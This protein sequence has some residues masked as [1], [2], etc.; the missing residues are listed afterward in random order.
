MARVPRGTLQ[1]H[2]PKSV[3]GIARVLPISSLRFVLAIWVVLYHYGGLPIF[4]GVPKE[5]LLWGLRAVFHNSISGPAAVIIFFII[6]GFCIHFPNRKS[7]EV[8]SWRRYYARRYLR[9][10]IPMTVAITL[11]VP[12]KM[13]F[14]LFTES[15]LW[16]LLCEEVYYLLYPM[17]LVARAR[18]GWGTLMTISWSLAFLTVL[19]NPHAGNY[20]SFGSKLNWVL[21]LPC[22]LLGCKLAEKFDH[23][24][25]IPITGA[26]IWTWRGGAWFLSIVASVLRFH[27]PIGYPWT[28][29]IFAVYGYFWLIQEIRYYRSENRRPL[30]EDLGEA[31]Y[32]IYLTHIHAL[33]I[34]AMLPI[35]VGLSPRVIWSW[36]VIVCGVITT[37]FYLLVERPSHRFARSYAKRAMW[38]Q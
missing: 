30:F 31:S 15:I 35:A 13:K 4:R 22:W 2:D 25:P 16:S 32:S 21:G 17:L 23:L 33:A 8:H 28:L 18:I 1:A 29:N 9:I 19:T 10:L 26:K 20:P 24:D 6:S 38:L 3:I 11:S 14:G 12:L 37:A 36:D 27:T 34:A 5:K 7:V